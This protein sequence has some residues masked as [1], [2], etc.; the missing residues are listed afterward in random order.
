LPGKLGVDDDCRVHAVA[1]EPLERLA[2]DVRAAARLLRDGDPLRAYLDML[3]ALPPTADA[4]EEVL[5]PWL[6]AARSGRGPRLEDR[7]A[8]AA[9]GA[10]GVAA[11][12]AADELCHDLRIA[13]AL[14]A[15]ARWCFFLVRPDAR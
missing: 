4:W 15:A 5:A 13:S 2:G 7:G 12:R 14:R 11:L 1:L 9:A 3:A 6:D 10:L 8:V